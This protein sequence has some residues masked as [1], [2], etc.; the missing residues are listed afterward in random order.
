MES[1]IS[2]VAGG[3]KQRISTNL[4]FNQKGDGHD[5]V[6]TRVFIAVNHDRDEKLALGYIQKILSND[7]KKEMSNIEIEEWYKTTDIEFYDA[8][9]NIKMKMEHLSDFMGKYTI[10]E[11]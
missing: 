7:E 5:F 4:F 11:L 8:L 10:E 9:S 1:Y 2:Y 3:K 6:A